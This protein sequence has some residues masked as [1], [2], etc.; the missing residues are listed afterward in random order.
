MFKCI[1]IDWGGT[2]S[3][4]TELFRKIAE[5]FTYPF[6]KKL[7]FKGTFEEYMRAE[8]K[9]G[10]DLWAMWKRNRFQKREDWSLLFSKNTGVKISNDDA[11]KEF[12][13]FWKGYAKHSS[14]LP[15]AES[16]LKFIKSKGIML[17]LV[18]NNFKESYKIFDKYGITK[19]FDTKI[20][21]EEAGAL[22]SEL[23]P[24]KFVLRKLK[25]TPEKC[26]M[27]GDKTDEDG[28]CRKLG[29]KFCLVDLEDK[30][31]GKNYEFDYRIT[32]LSE[33]GKIIKGAS[34]EV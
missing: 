30:H 26:L 31:A 2:L 33:L 17:A 13:L 16:T 8:K 5:E 1:M 21:S 14:L 29:I 15:D 18:S 27:V 22:K 9:T 28:A 34:K 10:E 12:N 19:L 4:E 11:I 7:G 32:K 25:I 6:W 23:E 3:D 20:L 24:F